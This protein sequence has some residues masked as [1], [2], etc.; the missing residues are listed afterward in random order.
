MKKLKDILLLLIVLVNM[1]IFG[2]N[3]NGSVGISTNL[4]N[5]NTVLHAASPGKN[6]GVLF[7]RLTTA[8]R[9][10]ITVN[11]AIDNGLTIYNTTDHCFNFWS[12]KNNEW[13]TLCGRSSNAKYTIDCA[14]T[15]VNGFYVKSKNLNN[16][17]YISLSVN[18]TQVGNY[19]I[20]TTNTNGYSFSATGTFNN[21]GTQTIQA[22]GSGTPTN[23]QTDNLSISANG[24]SINCTP[25]KT[26]TVY[27]SNST[28]SIDCTN[29]I[30]NGTYKSGTALTSANTITLPV[31]VTAL[32]SYKISTNT[33][34]GISFSTSG[35]FTSTGQQNVT[36]S[37]QGT[38][39]SATVKNFTIT[40]DSQGAFATT[41]SLNVVMTISVKTILHIGHETAYG[42]SAYT[43]PSRQ[44]IDSSTNFGTSTNSVVKSEGFNHISLGFL[45]S[46]ATLLA[47]LNN[48]P[49]IVIIGYDSYGIDATQAGYL[50]DYLNQKGV[51]I[52]FQ[53]R[54][55]ANVSLNFLKTV[56]SSPS[57]T[58]G[59]VG[60]G[61]GAVYP[62]VTTNDPILNGPFGDVRGK[63]WG[64]DASTTT[65]LTSGFPG[66]GPSGI[67]P[68]SYAQPLNNATVFN[69]ITGFKHNNLNLVWF[70]D[71]GFISNEYINGNTYPSY[72]IEP[73]VAPSTG[74]YLPLEKT[75]Y[76]FAGNGYVAGGL[77][78]Q[79]SIVFANIMAWAIKQAETNGINKP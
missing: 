52:A 79:N 9:D 24:V 14:N 42:Y 44:L 62:L 66:N 71:G 67:T 7:P 35:I 45:P 51:I 60:G 22:I 28:Y 68:L 10:A 15:S 61:A 21:L 1:P 39:T 11:T 36:L 20:S 55:D 41:C 8:E 33:V 74:G 76:G 31:N 38:P 25:A 26:V 46:N 54:P 58:V 53:D 5:P 37:G 19:Y 59:Y 12:S 56:L 78:V 72:V 49:D 57:L 3:S 50:A 63:N 75:N 34:D 73:F 30:V 32:G 69:G 4:P 29:A 2:Q 43:G 48:K 77:K 27:N 65:A 6:K 70:G 64:E 47:A 23:A 13:K 17:N 40:S 16:S 18:V